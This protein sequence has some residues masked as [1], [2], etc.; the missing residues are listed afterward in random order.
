MP[1]RY[2]RGSD[3]PKLRLLE[4]AAVTGDHHQRNGGSPLTPYPSPLGRGT[5]LHSRNVG[6]LVGSVVRHGM[7]K[8]IILL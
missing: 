8:R 4:R 6:P 5:P 1:L 7:V 2:V 3:I